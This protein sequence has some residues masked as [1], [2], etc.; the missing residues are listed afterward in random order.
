MA[1]DILSEY[2]PDSPANQKPRATKGGVMEFRDVMG[3][4][5]PYGPTNIG[6]RG[7]GLHGE[8]FGCCGTQGP[9]STPTAESGSPGLKGSN[10]GSGNGGYGMETKRG[11]RSNTVK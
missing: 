8:N 2:G 6:D 3:Y 9:Y 11:G 1:R 4:A 10:Y 7:P 5:P